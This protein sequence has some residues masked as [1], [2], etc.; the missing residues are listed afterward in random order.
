[1]STYWNESYTNASRYSCSKCVD[2]HYNSAFTVVL[3][4]WTF[5]SILL[6]I[7]NRIDNAKKKVL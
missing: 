2:I 3:T 5:L 7:R 4:V 6:A 1:M